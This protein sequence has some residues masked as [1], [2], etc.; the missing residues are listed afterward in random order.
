MGSSPS[1][2]SYQAPSGAPS[3]SWT[4]PADVQNAA[5]AADTQSYNASDADMLARYPSLVSGNQAF[6]QG[7]NANMQAVSGQPAIAAGS[8]DP[9]QLATARQAMINL[10]VSPAAAAADS[11]Q[12]VASVYNDYIKGGVLQGTPMTARAGQAGVPS[13]TQNA[14]AAN[15]AY[16]AALPGLTASLTGAGNSMLTSGQNMIGTGQDIIGQG[17]GLIPTGQN[18]IGQGQKIIKEGQPD[19]AAG[20]N[21]ISGTNPLNPLIQ[22]QMMTAGLGSAAGA[23]G[24]GNLAAGSAGQAAVAANLGLNIN[25]YIQQQQAQG[26][27]LQNQGLN[28]ANTGSGVIG[29]GSG[30]LG[31]ASNLIG[32]GSNVAGTGAGVATA[33]GNMFNTAGGLYNNYINNVNSVNQGA[34]QGEAIANSIMQP[35]TYGIGGQGVGNVLTSDM[36][37]AN[38]MAAYLYGTKVQGAQ[39]NTQIAGA[40][41]NAAAQQSGQLAGLGA[42]AVGTIGSIAAI[43]AISCWTAREIFGNLDPRWTQ[44]RFWMLNVG[45]KSFRKAYLNNGQR[46]AEEVKCD[47]ALKGLV[48]KVM[49]VLIEPYAFSEGL[50][51]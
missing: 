44:F 49:Q 3:F 33:G 40:N 5:I 28:F 11:D 31:Q 29:A 43:A 30:V 8:Y 6:S 14:V 35:R 16:G 18:I 22:Q 27:A 13:Q 51:A 23:L 25:Q 12:Q 32:A 24:S 20:Q 7:T 37:S 48:R 4:N 15:N 21:L 34:N 10:G 1:I 17:Q 50:A 47:L 2:P 19:I 26:I 9:T 38:N 46:W 41:S 42:S 39:L 45:P 36:A